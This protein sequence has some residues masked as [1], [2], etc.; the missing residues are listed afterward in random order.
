M[1]PFR[2]SGV[3]GRSR[4]TEGPAEPKRT[5]RARLGQ[6]GVGVGRLPTAKSVESMVLNP[7]SPD[8]HLGCFQ[9]DWYLSPNLDQ[10]NWNLRHQASEAFQ[11]ISRDSHVI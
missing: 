2:G 4:G 5:P 7:G 10:Q 11:D 9:K 6:G 1:Q 8:T 3:L